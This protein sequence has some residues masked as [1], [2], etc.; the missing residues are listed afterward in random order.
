MMNDGVNTSYNALQFSARHRMSH[1]YT[2]LYNYTYSHCLQDTETLGNKLQGNN[3]TDPN[4]MRFDYGPCDFDVRQNMNASFVYAGY[5]FTNRTM[6]LIAGGWSPSFLVSFNTGYPFTVLTGTDNS[7]TGIGL[8][9]PVAVPG[10]NRYVRNTGT[11]PGSMQWISAS[12]FTPN[13]GGSFGNVGMNSLVGP[14]YVNSDVSLRKLFTTFREQKLELR[15]EFFN[16]FNHPQLQAPVTKESSGSF[17]QIQAAGNPR[18]LQLA[19]K[20]TF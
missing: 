3:Q 15:F 1:G 4:N 7:L 2:L 9:R 16:I 18:I 5:N 17:G 19:G 14:R 12:A 8:D 10:A 20:Y 13:G 11:G 6:N